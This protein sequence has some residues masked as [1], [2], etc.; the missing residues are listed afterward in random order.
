MSYDIIL[1]KRCDIILAMIYDIILAVRS[2]PL[3]YLRITNEIRK[4]EI[5]KVRCVKHISREIFMHTSNEIRKHKKLNMKAY[6]HCD[7]KTY[8]TE[9]VKA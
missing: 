5:I 2:T 4:H 8:H 9:I 3:G 7:M 6:Q 1:A